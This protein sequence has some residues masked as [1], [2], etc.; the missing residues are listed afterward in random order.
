MIVFT[1][2]ELVA[3]CFDISEIFTNCF[4]I[5]LLSTIVHQTQITVSN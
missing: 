2:A 5:L 1:L 4:Q 3:F